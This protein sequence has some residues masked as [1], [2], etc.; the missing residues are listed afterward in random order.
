MKG[1]EQMVRERTLKESAYQEI[2]NGIMD[3]RH[4]PE[5]VLT[6]GV[7]MQQYGFK[8]S[9]I[10]EALI[11][12]CKDNMLESLPRVGYRL[13][14]I[15]LRDLSQLLDFRLMLETH[16]LHKAFPHYTEERLAALKERTILDNRDI[17]IHEN[18]ALSQYWRLNTRFHMGLCEPCGNRYM[19]NTLQD[20][21]NQCSRCVPEYYRNSWLH[22]REEEGG[23]IHIMILDALQSGD[24]EKA[25]CCLK[26]DIL[27]IKYAL[28]TE[29]AGE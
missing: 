6:E 18:D 23:T 5:D 16:A 13:K 26:D 2:L 24:L 7:L 27:Q 15:S 21:I 14:T 11:E 12:L 29:M 20:L 8:K 19:C 25:A 28:I 3:G 17:K 10:R 22:S 9:T 1:R 4:K